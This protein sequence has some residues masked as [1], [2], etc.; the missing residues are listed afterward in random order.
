MD[1]TGERQRGKGKGIK[2]ARRKGM[3]EKLRMIRMTK[4]G[5]NQEKEKEEE[6]KSNGF[7]RA[8]Q[9]REQEKGS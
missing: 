8:K 5:L 2:G 1:G 3:V 6:M 7:A 9:E 4:K